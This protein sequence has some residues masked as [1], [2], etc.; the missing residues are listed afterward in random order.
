MR[1]AP[2][3]DRGLS[4][5]GQAINVVRERGIEP[6]RLVLAAQLLDDVSAVGAVVASLKQLLELNLGVEEAPL[7][8]CEVVVKLMGT[9][10][11]RA[12]ADDVKKSI[13][14]P[15]DDEAT[16]NEGGLATQL[17]YIVRTVGKARARR[18]L[19]GV[20]DLLLVPTPEILFI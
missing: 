16:V 6:D 7:V 20:I 1:H 8:L 3:E 4:G 5:V 15:H 18:Y 11:T 12:K 2:S 10:S 9:D 17:S 19:R 13:S 14:G